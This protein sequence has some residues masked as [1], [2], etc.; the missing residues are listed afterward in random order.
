M[1]NERVA[2][3]LVLCTTPPPGCSPPLTP[4]A[5]P[6][7]LLLGLELKPVFILSSFLSS[8][9]RHEERRTNKSSRSGVGVDCIKE[10][11]LSVLGRCVVCDSVS[12]CGVSELGLCV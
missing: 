5:S 4:P 3:T 9:L 2:L 12:L 11:W 10:T 6:F 1:S 8:R 7:S